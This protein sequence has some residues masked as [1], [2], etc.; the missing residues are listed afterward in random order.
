MLGITNIGGGGGESPIIKSV[1]RGVRSGT[2]T[3]QSI[4]ISINTVDPAKCMV[5]V[6]GGNSTERP[7]WGQY[8]GSISGPNTLVLTRH[9]GTTTASSI[10][11]YWE[12]VEFG[13]A[14]SMQRGVADTSPSPITISPVNVG[15]SFVYC[16]GVNSKT[17]QNFRFSPKVR[18][19]DSTTLEVYTTT[20]NALYWF[21]VEMP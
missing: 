16:T 6:Q 20:G 12:V 13:E 9:T 4:S 2:N 7:Y 21:V 19:V 14:V 1:Q 18:L 8:A 10:E 11:V 15:K 3:A 5:I 17:T